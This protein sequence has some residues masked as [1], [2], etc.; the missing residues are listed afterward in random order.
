MACNLSPAN[1][2]SSRRS[3]LDCRDRGRQGETGRPS[4]GDIGRNGEPGRLAP[5][6]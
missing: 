1:S 3:F 2:A 4:I 5:S 6:T